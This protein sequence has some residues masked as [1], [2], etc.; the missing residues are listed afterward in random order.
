MR[1]WRRRRLRPMWEVQRLVLNDG[2]G[3]VVKVDRPVTADQAEWIK[4]TFREA[5]GDVA[6]VVLGPGTD[7]AVVQ[8]AA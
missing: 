4:R 5:F 8:V 1:W 2:D 3:L 6:V 7:L